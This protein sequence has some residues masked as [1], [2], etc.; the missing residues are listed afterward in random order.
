MTDEEAQSAVRILAEQ[1]GAAIRPEHLAE[2][3][4]AWRLMAPHLAR[5]RQARLAPDQEPAALFRP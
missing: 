1:F 4:A 2:T 5:V 3:A